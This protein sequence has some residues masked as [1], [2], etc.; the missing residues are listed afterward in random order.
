M[1]LPEEKKIFIHEENYP[2]QVNEETINWDE[3]IKMRNKE[4]KRKQ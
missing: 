1:L 2:L 4:W 3:V